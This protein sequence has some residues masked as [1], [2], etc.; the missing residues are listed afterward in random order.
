MDRKESNFFV[1]LISYYCSSTY[2]I[3]CGRQW[4][5]GTDSDI[6]QVASIHLAYLGSSVQRQ[7]FMLIYITNY[8]VPCTIYIS[9]ILNQC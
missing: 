7:W 2:N 5:I 8:Y 6:A 9:M 3:T 4:F 1:E